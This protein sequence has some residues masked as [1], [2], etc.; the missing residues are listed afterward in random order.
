MKISDV[1][2][3]PLHG[4]IFILTN[5]NLVEGDFSI[6]ESGTIFGDHEDWKA[7]GGDL[8]LVLVDVEPEEIGELVRDARKNFGHR[9][10]QFWHPLQRADDLTSFG[11]RGVELVF[12]RPRI[13]NGW[14]KFDV[15]PAGAE[16]V[17]F[18]I[19]ADGVQLGLLTRPRAEKHPPVVTNQERQTTTM[20]ARL[21]TSAIKR[22]KPMKKFLPRRL[23][24]SIYK[25]LNA[26][27]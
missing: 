27:K 23:I 12:S 9:A 8:A 24:V 5:G 19:F 4:S 21:L 7:Y 14:V 10:V 2:T 6:A 3:A 20:R 15:L 1:T 17:D 13:E 25:L 18:N 11:G 16:G 26:V 22:G